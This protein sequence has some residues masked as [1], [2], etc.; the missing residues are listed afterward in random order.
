MVRF[1]EP[2]W[3][4]S[5]RVTHNFGFYLPVNIP[6]SKKNFAAIFVLSPIFV[7]PDSWVIFAGRDSGPP[8]VVSP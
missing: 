6:P 2:E 3:H 8:L 4:V 1:P 7:T 5:K